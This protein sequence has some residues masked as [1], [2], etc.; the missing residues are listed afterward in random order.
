MK[1]FFLFFML[2]GWSISSSAQQVVSSSGDSFSTPAGFID[3]TVGEVVVFTGSNGTNDIT[4]GFHQTNWNFLSTEVLNY[5]FEATLYPNPTSDNL[6][7]KASAFESVNYVFMDSQGKIVR[8]GFL[9]SEETHLHV[10]DLAT[11]MY[12]ITLFK[13]EAPLVTY[14]LVKTQ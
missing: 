7:I 2:S 4:Q 14:Q 3:I 12:A 13:N 10:A 1:F 5:Q 8:E 9:T 6:N 11:G